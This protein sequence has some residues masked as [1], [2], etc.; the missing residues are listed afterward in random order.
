MFVCYTGTFEEETVIPMAMFVCYTGTF[1]E[2][3]VIPMAYMTLDHH[4]RVII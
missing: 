2:E 3:T 4:L 1:E